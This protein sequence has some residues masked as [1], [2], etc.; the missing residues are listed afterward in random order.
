[1][2]L[3]STKGP[4]SKAKEVV[5][6]RFPAS[7]SATISG[8]DPHLI[9]IICMGKEVESNS[10]EQSGPLPA[11]CYCNEWYPGRVSAHAPHHSRA[12][13][14]KTW[15]SPVS[16]AWSWCSNLLKLEDMEDFTFYAQESIIS[17]FVLQGSRPR[18]WACNGLHSGKRALW[19]NLS[20]LSDAE[21][22]E[23]AYDPTKGLF[24]F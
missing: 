15:A 24:G 2:A 10:E 6:R 19:L 18:L 22:M 4:E 7:C 21:V 13:L 3:I 11:S 14:I 16:M 9:F 23:A 1:M 17:S 8:R 12:S 5:S 20:G